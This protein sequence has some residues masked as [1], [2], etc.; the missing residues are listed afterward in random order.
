MNSSL[1]SPTPHLAFSEN[2]TFSPFDPTPAVRAGFAS[3][4]ETIARLVP[5]PQA[6]PRIRQEVAGF[7]GKTTPNLGRGCQV[8]RSMIWERGAKMA[9]FEVGLAGAKMAVSVRVRGPRPD[10]SPPSHVP[11]RATPVQ[12]GAK[13]RKNSFQVFQGTGLPAGDLL[14]LVVVRQIGCNLSGFEF[15][16]RTGFPWNHG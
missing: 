14:L 4:M 2:H 5:E 1:L 13:E 16:S 7:L 8:S 6:N 12:G 15:R 10:G 11:R 9:E 3:G